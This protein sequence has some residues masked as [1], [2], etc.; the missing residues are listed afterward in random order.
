MVVIVAPDG[1]ETVP[2]H[3]RRPDE[4]GIVLVTLGDQI[5]TPTQLTG[6]LAA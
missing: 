6:S 3:L 1:V 4:P 2:A 5:E